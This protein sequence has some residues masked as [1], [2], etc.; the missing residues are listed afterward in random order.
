LREQQYEKQREN[1]SKSEYFN[2]IGDELA[3]NKQ[4]KQSLTKYYKEESQTII[5]K[6]L[7]SE[8]DHYTRQN[9]Q[10]Y[11][12]RKYKIVENM[13]QDYSNDTNQERSISLKSQPKKLNPLN[14]VRVGSKYSMQ[15]YRLEMIHWKPDL[16]ESG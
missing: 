12:I 11:Q 3:H 9:Y 2:L 8:H 7:Q 10:K 16:R 5:N 14:L 13:L 1:C 4:L 15:W 6:M